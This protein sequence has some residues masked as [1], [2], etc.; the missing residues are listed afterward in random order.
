MHRHAVA[1]SNEPD[2]EKTPR[3]ACF[4]RRTQSVYGPSRRGGIRSFCCA[5]LGSHAGESST[6]GSTLC[7]VHARARGRY[8]RGHDAWQQAFRRLDVMHDRSVM[9]LDVTFFEFLEVR[10]GVDHDRGHRVSHHERVPVQNRHC[11]VVL[12]ATG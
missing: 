4:M 9:L 10:R 1:I 11:A 2:V 12:A 5:G 7:S 6:S 8:P 3:T